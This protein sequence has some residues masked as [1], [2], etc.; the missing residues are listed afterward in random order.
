M[1]NTN[2]S[3][4]VGQPVPN[5]KRIL[6]VDDEPNIAR[7]VKV[8]L[9]RCGY[10]VE[11]AENGLQALARIKANRPDLLISDVMMPE[12]DGF[13]LMAAIRSDAKIE[14]M[15]FLLMTAKLAGFPVH[16]KTKKEYIASMVGKMNRIIEKPFTPEQL[17]TIIGDMLCGL[18]QNEGDEVG[19]QAGD[20]H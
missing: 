12:M 9:E 15:P 1:D 10:E 20:C 11:T 19:T 2:S 4:N 18:G 5:G 13:E 7:L 17:K 3:A 8:V 6:A 16:Y 14:D